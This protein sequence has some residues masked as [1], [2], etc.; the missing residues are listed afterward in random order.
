MNV[1]VLVLYDYVLIWLQD[2]TPIQA[3]VADCHKQIVGV[4]I[5]RAEE[6]SSQPKT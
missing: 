2:G 1:T 5:M 3:Y 6:V 4:A